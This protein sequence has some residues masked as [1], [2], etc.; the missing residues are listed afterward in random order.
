MIYNGSLRRGLGWVL[1]FILMVSCSTQ[2]NTR[3]SRFYHNLNAHYNVYFNANRAY[4]EAEALF[5][6]QVRLDYEQ[7]LPVFLVGAK[8][9][10][11]EALPLL[12]KA[13]AKAYTTVQ[14]HSITQKPTPKKGKLTP[15]DKK[16]YART[17]FCDYIDESYL[18]IGR[19]YAFLLD[20]AN[21][22]PAFEHV[23]ATFPAEP[24]AWEAQL[25]LALLSVKSGDHA[26]ADFIFQKIDREKKFPKE[27]FFLNYAVRAEA[28][29][30][31]KDD[32]RALECVTGALM[33]F[34]GNKWQKYR[35]LFLRAQL[36]QKTGNH[37]AA[38]QAYTK[39]L[40]IAEIPYEMQFNA[41]LML[42]SLNEGINAKLKKL[43]LQMTEDPRNRPYAD[44]IWAVLGQLAMQE[45]KAEQAKQYYENALSEDHLTPEA[46]IKIYQQL[47]DGYFKE[48]N[49]I[50]A[51]PVLKQM[52]EL[53]D[54]N[55]PRQKVTESLYLKYKNLGENLERIERCDSLLR[56]AN[57]PE[58]YRTAWAQKLVEKHLKLQF[59]KERKEALLAERKVQKAS[60]SQFYFYNKKLLEQGKQE[61]ER[62]WGSRRQE[63]GWRRADQRLAVYS[64]AATHLKPAAGRDSVVAKPLS[65][66]QPEFYLRQI[67]QTDS[68]IRT[69]KSALAQA[70]YA[71]GK[72]YVDELK[73][74]AKGLALWEKC[75]RL[76]PDEP[77]CEW[78]AYNLALFY[79]SV[80]NLV[81]VEQ[82]K[83]FLQEKFPQSVATQQLFNPGFA[84]EMHQ[85]YRQ[86]QDLLD[87]VSQWYL[88]EQYTK[89]LDQGPAWLAKAGTGEEARKIALMLA[90]SA[91]SRGADAYKQALKDF[92]RAHAGTEEGEYARNRLAQLASED[93]KKMP[94]AVKVEKEPEF[95][96]HQTPYYFAI[97]IDQSARINQLKF[98]VNVLNA[99][100]FKDEPMPGVFD[101]ELK[102]GKRIVCC[103]TFPNLDAA[104]HYL[105]WIRGAPTSL[106]DKVGVTDAEF[107]LIS[108][109]N[110]K[111]LEQTG[112]V[113]KYV[114]FYRTQLQ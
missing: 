29:L 16:F 41:R 26:Q 84:S 15:E 68:A 92:V 33:D 7:P 87:T 36:L 57:M 75:L 10:L 2:K 77:A 11:V 49:Y 17:E 71:A 50:Q 6:R 102:G 93:E 100:R 62:L 21:A 40:R 98:N 34:R 51:Y 76:L 20:N 74:P 18:I 80:P 30:A 55:H 70:Y 44:R 83:V 96:L 5:E 82:M 45:G 95:T 46:K 58:S 47:L 1:G 43:L 8:D 67:P 13:I 31:R 39:L 78:L 14:K 25:W 65:P 107:V 105:R 38:K 37:P 94:V 110:L 111:V 103:G 24:S 23:S 63:D 108:T 69:M 112:N 12:K 59:E 90:I 72:A 109:R 89:L 79:K 81:G 104:R 60:E 22:R 86:R 85:Q 66:N 106:L 9:T 53:M 35:L 56:I 28:A 114:Q 91:G 88:K 73:E 64:G 3:I 32:A 42:A 113:P 61:F 101:R 97:I 4:E 48:K 52:L 19:S 27:L 54:V 99:D